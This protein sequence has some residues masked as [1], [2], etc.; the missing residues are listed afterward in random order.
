MNQRPITLQTDTI[1]L[2]VAFLLRRHIPDSLHGNN[3]MFRSSRRPVLSKGNEMISC[4][5][6]TVPPKP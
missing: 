6:R 5:V 4:R 3:P 2:R 1:K